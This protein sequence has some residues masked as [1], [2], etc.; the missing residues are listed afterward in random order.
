MAKKAVGAVLVHPYEALAKRFRTLKFFT[1]FFLIAFL[2]GGL[3]ILH[4]LFT[5]ENLRYLLKD[6]DV[7]SP[8][9]GMESRGFSFDFDTTQRAKLYRG[10][11]ALIRRSGVEVYS[12]SGNQ[13]LSD[14][15]AFSSPELVT[16]EKYLLAYDI[17]GHKVNLY[18]GFSKLWEETYP[19]SIFCADLSD[20][21]SF[22]VVT[23]EKGYHSALYVYNANFEKIF[24]W[25]SADKVANDVSICKE[26]PNLV[27]VSTLKSFGGELSCEVLVFRV[28]TA[29]VYQSYT[30]SGEMPIRLDFISKDRFLLLTDEALHLVSPANQTEITEPIDRDA[31]SR[32]Y[33]D[34][35]YAVLVKDSGLIGTSLSVCVYELDDLVKEPTRFSLETQILDIA[36]SGRTLYFLSYGA[37]HSYKLDSGNLTSSPLKSEFRQILPLSSDR[38][39]FLG[40]GFVSI[41]M[42]G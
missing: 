2:L 5:V 36:S 19:Y 3:L 16:S 9:A 10:D 1:L 8:M 29:Q 11:L 20:N 33:C 31:L 32:Y 37:L 15:I 23:G 12:L 25:A 39:A 18:N 22:T 35:Q 6:L 40:E 13:S 38:I 28:D 7:S 34:G 4:N 24:R 26:D 14:S 42:V 21:G 41:Y 27:A 30:I 17:G